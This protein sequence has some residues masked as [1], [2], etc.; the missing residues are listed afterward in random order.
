MCVLYLYDNMCA[1]AGIPLITAVL[2]SPNFRKAVAV[3]DEVPVH[4]VLASMING[5]FT[6]DVYIVSYWKGLQEQKLLEP[7]LL[8]QHGGLCPLNNP[9][10]CRYIHANKFAIRAPAS[11]VSESRCRGKQ[12]ARPP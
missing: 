8:R 1:C 11:R 9:R 3:P 12:K 10:Y 2:A 6:Y 5:S 7:Q 4:E